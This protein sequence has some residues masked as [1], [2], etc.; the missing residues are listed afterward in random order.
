ML[1]IKDTLKRHPL[2]ISNLRRLINYLPFV[3]V[4][5]TACKTIVTKTSAVSLSAV[6]RLLQTTFLFMLRPQR[7]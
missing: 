2:V 3:F 1:Q 6:N 7:K 5:T 4:A